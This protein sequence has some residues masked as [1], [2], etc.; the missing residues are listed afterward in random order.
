MNG[1]VATVLFIAF[2]VLWIYPVVR[3]IDVA[4]SKNYSTAWM[5]FGIHHL[6]PH[7]RRA[8][9]AVGLLGVEEVEPEQDPRT[10]RPVDLPALEG[11]PDLVAAAS[12]GV[13]R[14]QASRHEEGGL[15]LH[16]EGREACLFREFR[17][18]S[19]RRRTSRSA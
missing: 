18:A 8:V 6:A 2:A 17:R 12:V 1:I 9:A 15:P 19:G 11:L 10:A 5:W 13:Q 4:K 7:R 16:L 14:D 3:G